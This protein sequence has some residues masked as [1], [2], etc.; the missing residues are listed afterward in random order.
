MYSKAVTKWLV[1]RLFFC[2]KVFY[3]LF[4]TIVYQ[5]QSR[6]LRHPWHAHGCPCEAVLF[7]T[8]WGRVWLGFREFAALLSSGKIFKKSIALD[9]FDAPEAMR[10]K[11][12]CNDRLWPTSPF[13]DAPHE[14]GIEDSWFEK[15][16]QVYDSMRLGD[17]DSLPHTKGWEEV[18][19]KLCDF[20]LDEHGNL[21]REALIDFRKEGRFEKI[22]GDTFSQVDMHA[23]YTTNY[24]RAIDLVLEY[25]RSA[26]KVRKEI[27]ASLSESHAGNGAFVHYHGL[28]LSEK[29]LFYSVVTEDL[30]GDVPFLQEEDSKK[31]V[32]LDIGGGYG[33][34]C[35]ILKRYAPGHC[36][37]LTDLPE[38]TLIAAYYLRYIFPDAKISFYDDMTASGYAAAVEESDFLILPA[39]A[40]SGVEEKSVDLVITTASL[41]FLSETYLSYYMG[42]IDRVLKDGG[43][44]YSV[45][46]TESCQWGTGLYEADFK[47]QY[48]TMLL[49]YNNRF[50][51]PQWLGKKVS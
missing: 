1:K 42:E 2:K 26:A 39:G 36:Y 15:I 34:L 37:V 29:L 12:G 16:A 45:N 49:E 6:F 8:F 21:R 32:I 10:L 33:G 30:L 24:L 46:K 20:L 27:L 44:F 50:S 3:T 4:D 19:R 38:V 14:H 40:L 7:Y 17:H 11:R 13:V 48:I 9:G 18:R 43:Y 23:D 35:A 25:H 28:R 31:R 47:A 51:Y 41:G 5:P 22:I